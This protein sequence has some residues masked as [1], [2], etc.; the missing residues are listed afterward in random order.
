MGFSFVSLA[1]IAYH[2]FLCFG[3]LFRR[4]SIAWLRDRYADHSARRASRAAVAE[5]GTPGRVVEGAPAEP[6][7]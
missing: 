4:K 3:L 7:G 5:H 1:E 2:I 6:T